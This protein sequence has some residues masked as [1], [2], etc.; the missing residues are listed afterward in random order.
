MIRHDI[1][2]SQSPS[3]RH[4]F[5]LLQWCL[6]LVLILALGDGDILVLLILG[7]QI[8]HVGLGLSELHLVH[9]LT[10]IPMQESLSS[11]HGSELITD[12]L[13]ELLDRG[14]VTNEGGGHL[15]TTGWD[16]AEGGLDVV[17]DPLNEVGSVLVL[18]V[19]HL[20]LNLLHGDLTTAGK[21]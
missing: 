8:V 9:T 2:A 19:S 10:S 18:D 14:R 11:E 21:C 16:G 17:G 20:I 6:L 12:T 15:K 7:Y 1:N 13:E 4:L 5:L 3:Q